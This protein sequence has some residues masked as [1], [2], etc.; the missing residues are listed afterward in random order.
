MFKALMH[1]KWSAFITLASIVLITIFLGPAAGFL[2]VVLIAI[3]VAFSFDNAVVNAKILEHLSPLW[4]KLFLTV[5]ILIAV[6]GMRLVFPILIV[7]LAANL[8]WGKVI[9][10][11]LNNP[12]EYARY[13]EIAHPS[14]SAF[15]GAFLLTLALYFLFDRTR[16]EHWLPRIEKPL[17]K[18]GGFIWLAPLVAI[19]FVGIAASLPANHYVDTTLKAGA[20]GVVVYTVMH[21]LITVMDKN[22]SKFTTGVKRT[23]W[24]AFISFMYLE[25]LDA[26]FSFDG[27][28][29]A[30]A[31]SNN[32]ILIAVGL[33]VGA[34]WV[35]TL[36][37][38]LVKH[39]SLGK[40]PY[41]DH[42]AHYAILALAFA[43]LISI[44]YH[45]PEVFTGLVGIVIILISFYAS[46]KAAKSGATIEPTTKP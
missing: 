13:L 37:V 26:S 4:Q 9:D 24:A 22:Q 45:I 36:T 35:R 14:I 5:G 19:G 17:Q 16:K 42:G 41:L 7:A 12:D 6:F 25:I 44:S 33:G 15:G 31:I 34:I 27:V 28:L 39:Q 20:L 40:Y 38:Q 29:G 18:L 30:F 1:V 10:L 46:V 8:S 43:L 3:E 2:M 11:A 23:G 21:L 32:V